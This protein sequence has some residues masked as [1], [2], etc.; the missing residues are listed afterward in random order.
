MM[1]WEDEITLDW[2]EEER[3]ALREMGGWEA[4]LADALPAGAHFRPYPGSEGSLLML[5]EALHMDVSVAEPA[6]S[7]P[8]LRGELFVELM[9]RGLQSAAVVG[10][11]DA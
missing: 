11:E 6:P 8:E 2:D 4:T 1:I 3:E 10:I 7:E 5:W 9:L